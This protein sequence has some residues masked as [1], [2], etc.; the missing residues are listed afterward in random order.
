VCKKESTEKRLLLA[1]R[2]LL[3]FHTNGVENE[4]GRTTV[5]LANQWTQSTNSRLIGALE[6]ET[7]PAV[8]PGVVY[9]RVI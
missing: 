7:F 8:P 4:M 5:Y 2:D 9:Q 3:I 6:M 1:F